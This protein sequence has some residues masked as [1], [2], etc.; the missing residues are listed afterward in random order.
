[1]SVPDRPELH[2][3]YDPIA[4][5]A[6]IGNCRTAALVSRS[7][8]IDWYCPGQFDAPATFCRLLDAHRG[9][10]LSV[11]P[12]GEVTSERRYLGESAI[13]ETV[14]RGDGFEVRVVDFMPIG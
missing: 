6:L 9:G 12:A 10:Y 2:D 8:S 13:L 11:A 3:G 14:H 7:G 1:M 5:Y 4:E